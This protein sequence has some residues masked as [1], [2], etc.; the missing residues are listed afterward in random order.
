[1][2]NAAGDLAP[3]AYEAYLDDQG[4]TI[5]YKYGAIVILCWVMW[6]MNVTFV[7]IML[8]NFLVGIVCNEYD[9]VAA[10]QEFGKFGQRAEFNREYRLFKNSFRFYS[11]YDC[12]VYSFRKEEERSVEAAGVIE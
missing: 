9:N 8:F 2:R 5:N 4:D 3:P 1:M 7:T 6:F 12:L 11:V 10:F